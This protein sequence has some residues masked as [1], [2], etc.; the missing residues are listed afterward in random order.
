MSLGAIAI[1]VHITD[2]GREAAGFST[3]NDAG[4]CVVRACA[5]AMRR[6]Y[7]QV[8][9]DIAQLMYDH[10]GKRTARDAVP[11]KITRDYFT[12]CGWVWTP[13][14][15]IGSGCRVHLDA[16]ELPPGRLVCQLSK[17]VVAVVDGVVYDTHD[18]SRGGSRCV[19]G[20]WQGL[21]LQ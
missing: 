18:P 16:E 15:A 9:D 10:K 11:K 12:M 17:H 19:Y 3:A 8:Y 5:I 13:T 4:D 6:D 21:V 20:Y 2:G 7:R 1:P 14:M